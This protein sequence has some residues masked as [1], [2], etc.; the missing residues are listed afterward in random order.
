MRLF[1]LGITIL[2]TLGT[3]GCDSGRTDEPLPSFEELREEFDGQPPGRGLVR[4]DNDSAYETSAIHFTD[5]DGELATFVVS[6][7]SETEQAG[8]TLFMEGVGGT[9]LQPN[10]QFESL[11]VTYGGAGCAGSG[12]GRIEITAVADSLIAGVFAADVSTTTLVP[13]NRRLTGGFT[14]IFDPPEE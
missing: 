4:E 3:A 5:R 12:S 7:E 13:C 8:M 11:Q 2:F 10:M 14:A 1:A 9:G 6:L